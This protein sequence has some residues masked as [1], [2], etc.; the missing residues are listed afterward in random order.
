[1][2]SHNFFTENNQNVQFFVLCSRSVFSMGLLR[3]KL[4][5]GKR[6]LNFPNRGGGAKRFRRGSEKAL[7]AVKW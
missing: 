4:L 6:H 2:P 7:V 3:P 5:G 1:M